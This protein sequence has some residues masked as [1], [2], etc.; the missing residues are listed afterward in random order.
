M[1]K[2]E[3]FIKMMYINVFYALACALEL[4]KE[5]FAVLHQLVDRNF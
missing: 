2:W 5:G 1:D 3:H 4:I